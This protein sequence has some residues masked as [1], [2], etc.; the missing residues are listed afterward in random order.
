[1]VGDVCGKLC[2]DYKGFV[3]EVGMGGGVGFWFEVLFIGEF[4]G[5]FEDVVVW[6]DG[7]GW[8]DEVVGKFGGGVEGD[9]VGG[10]DVGVEDGCIYWVGVIL[11]LMFGE[12]MWGFRWSDWSWGG[13]VREVVFYWGGVRMD[14][15]EVDG[16]EMGLSWIVWVEGKRVGRVDGV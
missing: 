2:F 13:W 11:Y 14:K 8:L 9:F 3:G 12:E 16:V 15:V 6:G 7:G 1:M 5:C 4:G 10:K